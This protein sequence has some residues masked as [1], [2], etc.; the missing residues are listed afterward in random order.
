MFIRHV[1][2]E[3]LL[4]LGQILEGHHL[5]QYSFFH[6][7][8]DLM[9]NYIKL[10]TNDEELGIIRTFLYYI[11]LQMG[12]CNNGKQ[13]CIL[14]YSQRQDNQQWSSFFF[15]YVRCIYIVIITYLPI[16]GNLETA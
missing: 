4:L 14:L 9:L 7:F 5:N 16:L 8:I 10:N 11:S 3:G 1:C 2:P 6:S 15:S 12:N 13:N